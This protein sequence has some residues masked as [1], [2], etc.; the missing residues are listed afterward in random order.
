M[1][2]QRVVLPD[3]AEA[4]I[5]LGHVFVGVMPNGKV[6]VEKVSTPKTTD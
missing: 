2:S 4:L 5:N 1:P 6:I 3:E